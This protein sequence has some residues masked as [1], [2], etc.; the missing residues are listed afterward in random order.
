MCSIK[1]R[2]STQED[3]LPKAGKIC[4]DL[5]PW[6]DV[7]SSL[8]QKKGPTVLSTLEAFMAG[9]SGKRAMFSYGKLG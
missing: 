3:I 8:W 4:M 2:I 1:E 9:A 5:G 6:K 7:E